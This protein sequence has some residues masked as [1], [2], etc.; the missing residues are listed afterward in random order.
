RWTL[1][2]VCDLVDNTHPIRIYHNKAF[3]HS[4]Y[5]LY[6]AGVRSYRLNMHDTDLDHCG[7][8]VFAKQYTLQTPPFNFIIPWEETDE[9][10][11]TG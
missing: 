2:G 3:H 1:Q 7:L 4:S 11:P 8:D 5:N 6:N 9:K 10:W